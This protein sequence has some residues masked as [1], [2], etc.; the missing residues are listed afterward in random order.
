M[1]IVEY[2]HLLKRILWILNPSR[3]EIRAY[4]FND[5]LLGHVKGHGYGN[6]RNQGTALV[7][8]ILADES[9]CIPVIYFP[10]YMPKYL[11]RGW[12]NKMDPKIN[13]ILSVPLPREPYNQQKIISFKI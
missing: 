12:S 1:L 13:S 4:V 2:L 11:I 9:S 5:V 7:L 10:V 8:C 3:D 6:I